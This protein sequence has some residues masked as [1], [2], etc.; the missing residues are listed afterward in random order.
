MNCIGDKL[1]KYYEKAYDFKQ[2]TS[3][4]PLYVMTAFDPDHVCIKKAR[5]QPKV[6]APGF[7][8]GMSFMYNVTKMVMSKKMLLSGRIS[9][10]F[11]D[12]ILIFVLRILN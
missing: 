6:L 5:N 7:E 3:K 10:D 9:K 12:F 8:I 2:V 1:A 4:T 11:D